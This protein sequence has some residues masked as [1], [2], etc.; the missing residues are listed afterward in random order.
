MYIGQTGRSIEMRVK[1]HWHIHLYHPKKSVVTEHSINLAHF[2][3]LHNTSILA[4]KSTRTG[5][6]IM[7]ATEIELQLNN[8]NREDSFSLSRTWPL[9][10]NLAERKQALNKNMTPFGETWKG[11][12]LLLLH[13]LPILPLCNL[14]KA[15]Y[16]SRNIFHILSLWF[17][18][19]PPPSS[20]KPI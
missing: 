2:I 19:F 20:S 1:E 10:F 13:S 17:A 6:I 4:K 18:P 16:L 9:I 11:Q 5:Q 7:K 8:I 14:L 3:Q 12:I 15:P